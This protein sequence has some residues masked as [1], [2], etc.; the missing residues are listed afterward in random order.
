MAYDTWGA[1]FG[2]SWA[3]SWTK[4]EAVPP[5]D[6]VVPP[7]VGG[8]IPHDYKPSKHEVSRARKR[9]GLE[10]EVASKEAEAV[11]AEVAARQVVRLE[12]DAQKRFEELSRELQLRGIEWESRYLE[13][14][15]VQR[16]QLI[17]AEIIARLR[18]KL[19]GE[20]EQLVLLLLVAAS[21]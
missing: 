15:N 13:S 6:V 3:L 2:T 8:G 18:S 7:L 11:I 16:E 1:S 17:D 19:K 4:D 20:D 9:L 21:L 12:Q 5:T 10:D 14:L